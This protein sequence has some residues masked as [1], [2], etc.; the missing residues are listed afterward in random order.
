MAQNSSSLISSVYKSRKTIL[1]LMEKQDYNIEQYDKFSINEVNSMFQ[2]KQL[3]LLLEKGE[4]QNKKKIYI[5]Y[6]LAKTLRPQ[7]VQ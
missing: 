2:N 3:D 6:Y 5:H 1:Q 4:G 7:N